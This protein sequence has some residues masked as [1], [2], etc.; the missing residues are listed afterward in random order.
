[1]SSDRTANFWQQAEYATSRADKARSDELRRAWLIV[2]RDW[3]NMARREEEKVLLQKLAY[4]AE[5]T[6]MAP[7]A[8][9]DELLGITGDRSE[10]AKQPA[11]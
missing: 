8:S 2:A 11:R 9:H 3:A 10:E 6:P 5:T 4:V 1:M 7:E